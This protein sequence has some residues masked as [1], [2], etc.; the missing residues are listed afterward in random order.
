MTLHF[1]LRKYHLARKKRWGRWQM[2]KVYAQKV[3]FTKI[4]LHMMMVLPIGL[5]ANE[6]A[7]R[8]TLVKK[9]RCS[10]PR[11]RYGMAILELTR[12]LRCKTSKEVLPCTLV[13][14][15]TSNTDIAPQL[16]ASGRTIQLSGLHVLLL[17]VVVPFVLIVVPEGGR[18]IRVLW[19]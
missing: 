14:A 12:L 10:F 9:I 17:A 3:R 15:F 8:L 18:K 11:L 5:R 13:A 6:S 16:K 4:S 2:V 1:S 19:W 7:N